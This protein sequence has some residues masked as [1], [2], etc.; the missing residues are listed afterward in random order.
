[1]PI[2]LKPPLSTYFEA[3]NAHD[4]AAVAALFGGSALVHDEHEDHRGHAAIRDWA[5]STYD[6]YKVKLTPREARR[7]AGIV[8]VTTGVVGTFPASPIE[9][10]FRF[11]VDG[12]KIGELRIG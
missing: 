6:K 11:T 4:A 9:L 7:E 12:D 1:M 8:F 2:E 5:Q 3:A 10:T